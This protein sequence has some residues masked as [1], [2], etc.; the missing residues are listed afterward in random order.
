MIG[1]HNMYK[2]INKLWFTYFNNNNFIL[3]A[4]YNTV[5]ALM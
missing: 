4:N 2:E 1:I 5:K 3:K